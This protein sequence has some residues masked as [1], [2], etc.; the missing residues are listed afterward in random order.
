MI[1]NILVEMRGVEPRSIHVTNRLSTSLFCFSKQT[2]YQPFLISTVE[3]LTQFTL[4]R[5]GFFAVFIASYTANASSALL[6]N[7]L[8]PLVRDVGID[9]M[10]SALIV[11]NLFNVV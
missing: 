2:K 10:S 4:L 6:A 8:L 5:S 11:L 7:T 9:I 1:L 3:L